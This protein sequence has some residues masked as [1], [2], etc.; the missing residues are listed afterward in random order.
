MPRLDIA[1]RSWHPHAFLIRLPV[2]NEIPLRYRICHAYT[3]SS[4]TVGAGRWSSSRARGGLLGLD[5][6]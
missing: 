5:M 2:V 4:L 1:I 3:D 6:I